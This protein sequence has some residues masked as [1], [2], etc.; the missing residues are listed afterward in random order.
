MA[1]TAPR[2]WVAGETV[3]AALGNTHWRDNLKAIGDAWTS[4]TPTFSGGISAIG[5]AV[6]IA[7]YM[8]AGKLVKGHVKV[9]MGST[10]TYAGS[11]IGITAPTTMA[12]ASNF[13]IGPGMALDAS[14][15][16]FYTV[17][18]IAV[19][20]SGIALF[21]NATGG[22]TNTVPFTWTTSDILAFSFS[23]EAA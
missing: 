3:T 7:K 11:N 5:N 20:S 10:T 6:V 19:G 18:P 16:L 17:T 23:Y 22:V 14:A 1:W 2:T 8:Q 15:G 4:Y 21:A 13:P 9:T 12:I